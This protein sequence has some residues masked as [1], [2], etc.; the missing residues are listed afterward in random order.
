ML[1]RCEKPAGEIEGLELGETVGL[2]V[3]PSVGRKSSL[4]P[5]G[6]GARTGGARTRCVAAAV[7]AG[8]RSC[9][10]PTAPCSGEE[11][12]RVRPLAACRR[13]L[14]PRSSSAWPP[15]VW[16]HATRGRG[17]TCFAHFTH[18]PVGGPSGPP[19]PP[20]RGHV[21]AK[22]ERVGCC[23]CCIVRDGGDGVGDRF[24]LAD[25]GHRRFP[26]RPSFCGILVPPPPLGTHPRRD[27]RPAAGTA[28]AFSTT[29]AIREGDAARAMR[30]V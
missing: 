10:P 26:S 4:P 12:K 16:T 20:H 11:G 17:G 14:S 18:T 21:T 15:V 29:T 24:R 9:W 22:R 30:P 7:P 25:G 5:R 1:S 8:T 13:T 27:T 19:P 2:N 6:G 3:G 23:G 28:R